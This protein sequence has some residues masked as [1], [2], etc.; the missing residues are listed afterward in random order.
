MRLD[1]YDR[2][3]LVVLLGLNHPIRSSWLRI[4]VVLCIVDVGIE[5]S[6]P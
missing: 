3:R 6:A 4:L 1:G 5:R 2:R